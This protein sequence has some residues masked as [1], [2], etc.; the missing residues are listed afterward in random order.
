MN[1][2]LAGIIGASIGVLAI[3]S[4]FVLDWNYAFNPDDGP[5][6]SEEE[7]LFGAPTA[8]ANYVANTLKLP[9]L[10]SKNCLGTDGSGLVQEG[11]CTGG[12]GGTGSNWTVFGGNG[13]LA[14]STTIGIIVQASSTIRNLS[15]VN[16]TATNATTTN[17]G[18]S[19]AISFAGDLIDELVGT[20][21]TL[22]AGDLQTTLG[23]SVAAN[24]LASADFGSFT[25]NGT[26]CTID[27]QA[28]SSSML[29]NADFGNFTV[30]GGTAT[31]D[32]ASVTNAMLAN[33]TISGIALGSNLANLTATDSTLTFSGTYTGATARTIGI[34]LSNP[35]TWTGLQIFGNAS[36]TLFSS[37]YASS[38]LGYFGRIFSLG[39]S[40]GCATWSSGE[41]NS[42][43]TPCG[44]GSG[45]LTSYDAFTHPQAGTSAT[46]SGMIFTAASSTFTGQISAANATTTLLTATTAWL[47]NLFVGAD[48][49]QEYISDT[50]G[51]M[52]SGNTE[53]GISITYQDADNT[54]DAVVS[55]VTSAMFADADWGDITLASGVAS[56]ED[57]SHAHTSTTISGLDISADTNLTAGDALTLTDD[58]IDFDGGATPAGDLGGTWALPSVTDDSHAHTSTT[59]SG[60][61]VSADLN[62]TGGAGLT[63]TGDDMACDTGSGTVFGCI[64][65][66]DW[67][68]FNNKWDL[69]SS[70][71]PISKGGTGLTAVGASSTVLTTNGTIMIWQS[72]ATYVESI[73]SAASLALTG[74][75][76]FSGATVKEHTYSSFSYSTT[77][78]WTGT[79]TIPLGPAYTAEDWVGAKCF[80]DTGTVNV[81]FYDGT[82]RM[83]L[84]NA[85]TTVGTVTLS[86]NDTFTASE[87]RYVDVG[88]PASS[89]TKFSCTIDKIVNN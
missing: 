17:L 7:K 86:T 58:D 5:T 47:T 72:I 60:L 11:T 50:A 73:I 52:W 85:S 49:I 63:L 84:F 38:T 8:G 69:A 33:S 78:A 48:T 79:T 20:G 16:A 36:S 76:N 57:D 82:N 66:A 64:T 28:V 61:D 25:C 83:N 15:V 71:I 54:I 68:T 31:I 24:E 77:T 55:G 65:A 74:T 59:I 40:D 45:G 37:S 26:T 81:S 27:A 39:K 75:W 32:N 46:T 43:G 9:N 53:T 13:W 18:I 80:T 42:T 70:T 23:T 30:S 41:L 3:A 62:L 12:S 10:L 4:G 6:W 2:I 56:V 35:N 51:G 87:K 29:A 19:G 1:G 88:T 14:P 44:S 89:P 21:L 67:T 22:S 34:N